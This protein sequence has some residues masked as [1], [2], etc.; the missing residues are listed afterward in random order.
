MRCLWLVAKENDAFAAVVGFTHLFGWIH[1][2]FDPQSLVVT[3][4]LV[5]LGDWFGHDKQI[6][7]FAV[8]PLG[9]V[10]GEFQV[11]RLV[12][13]D[14]HVSGAVEQDVGRHQ[15]W[16]VEETDGNFFFKNQFII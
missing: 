6:A 5:L 2:I 1:Q 8:H 12:V 3:K 15:D 11:L 14:W 4:E 16:V 10:A 13:A 7:K 9:D